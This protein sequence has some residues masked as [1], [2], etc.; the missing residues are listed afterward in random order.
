MSKAARRS[1]M[2]KAFNDLRTLHPWHPDVRKNGAK[3]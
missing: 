2:D 1:G 3:L